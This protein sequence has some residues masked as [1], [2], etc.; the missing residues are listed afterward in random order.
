MLH[1]MKLHAEMTVNGRFYAKGT[2]VPWT[3]VY[4]FFLLHMFVF[5]GSGFLMA[6]RGQPD[7]LF[8]Y[9]HG[10]IAISIYV[11]FYVALFGADEVKWMFI[12]AALGIAGIYS[13]VAW[14][15]GRFGRNINDVPWHVH[16]IPFL[17]YVLYVFLIRH[18][19]LDF[20]DAREDAVRRAKVEKAYVAVSLAICALFY[21]L[22]R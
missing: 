6:Y 17:Y 5:G 20:F 10:G 15:L 19:F 7:V 3:R 14:L 1:S 8:L 16:V 2:E 9:M 4:P 18:A 21:L 22:D 12:N 11:V 13:Q